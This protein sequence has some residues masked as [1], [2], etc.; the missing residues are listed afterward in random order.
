MH[1]SKRAPKTM[2]LCA[3]I[4]LLT[5][6][7]GRADT[8]EARLYELRRS[9]SD[10]D[11]LRAHAVVTADYGE[12]VYNYTVDLAGNEQAGTMT[13]TEPESI[14]GTVLQWSDGTTQLSVEGVSLET[15][16]LTETLSPN[17]AVPTLLSILREG[18]VVS[19]GWEEEFLSAQL[20]HPT[21]Q[22]LTALCWFDRETGSLRRC[23]L[24]ENGQTVLTMEFSDFALDGA[25]ADAS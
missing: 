21:D 22:G 17:H 6:C 25:E 16:P 24:A 9:F 20:S 14:A 7:A 2:A 1:L 12:R 13:V 4:L 19:C 8:P 18:E 10:M 3:L 15:G 11:A 5:A 23:E